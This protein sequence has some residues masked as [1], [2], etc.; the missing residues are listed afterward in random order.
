MAIILTLHS[1]QGITLSIGRN[2][3]CNH[4]LSTWLR[5][6]NLQYLK[7]LK[8]ISTTKWY[9]C[10][11]V[12]KAHLCAKQVLIN[13]IK[14]IKW[15][16]SAKKQIKDSIPQKLI[17]AQKEVQISRKEESEVWAYVSDIRAKYWL[18]KSWRA[19]AS[20]RL[21]ASTIWIVPQYTYTSTPN[22]NHM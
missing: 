12:H 1:P 10:L 15:Y 3:L 16:A 21:S 17:K 6:Y 20:N 19:L 4:L 8:R 11:P 13:M 18:S 7:A 5:L 2:F 22:V 14:I 9:Q